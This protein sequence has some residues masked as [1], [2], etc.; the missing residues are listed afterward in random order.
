MRQVGDGVAVAGGVERLGRLEQQD[1][2]RHEVGC[3]APLRVNQRVPEALVEELRHPHA[4]FGVEGGHQQRMR[5]TDVEQPHPDRD[6]REESDGVAAG[7]R[8][9]H[10]T[11]GLPAP[12]DPPPGFRDID[13][14][15]V[16]ASP[17][18]TAAGQSCPSGTETLPTVWA[19]PLRQTLRPHETRSGS[20]ARFPGSVVAWAQS[21]R[22]GLFSPGRPV[23]Q[24]FPCR[25]TC[26]E[27]GV[28]RHSA[29]ITRSRAP[30]G[31]PSW[32]RSGS[33][34]WRPASAPSGPRRWSWCSGPDAWC[35][36]A[37]A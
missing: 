26:V 21:R 27:P 36:P 15:V 5:I 32:A 22:P 34:W 1:V 8:P 6:Q 35:T 17:R 18:R 16:A 4:V 28:D 31:S 29:A 10:A 2:E 33:P 7:L 25:R 12:G 19:L 11:A 14:P 24:S 3:F 20:N 23:S 30:R 13:R 37:P 9:L